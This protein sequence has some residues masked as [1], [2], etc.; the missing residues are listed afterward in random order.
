MDGWREGESLVT[1]C[2]RGRG[3]RDEDGIVS[4]PRKD[5]RLVL[6]AAAEIRQMENGI[7]AGHFSIAQ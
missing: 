3:C 4:V 5:A 6:L 7:F 1:T 2:V